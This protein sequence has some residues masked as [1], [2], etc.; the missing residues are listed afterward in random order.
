MALQT[1][2]FSHNTLFTDCV[3]LEWKYCNYTQNA[4]HHSTQKSFPAFYSYFYV[5]YSQNNFQGYH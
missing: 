1:L 2:K 5:L 4:L 3:P